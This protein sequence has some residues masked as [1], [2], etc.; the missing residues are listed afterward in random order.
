MCSFPIDLALLWVDASDPNHQLQ[1]MQYQTKVFGDANKNYRFRSSGEIYQVILSA[2]HFAPWIRQIFVV[3]ADE[4]QRQLFNPD[5][6]ELVTLILHQDI[7]S[8]LDNLPTFNSHA[9]E[10]NIHNIPG[11]SEQFLYGNDDTFF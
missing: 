7:F 8:N 2:I 3:V 9:I 5:Y 11:L 4:S 1:K 6:K 10:C